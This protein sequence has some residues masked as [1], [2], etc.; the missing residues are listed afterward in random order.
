MFRVVYRPCIIK[1]AQDS[2]RDMAES[3]RGRASGTIAAEMAQVESVRTRSKT[4]RS[5]SQVSGA[6]VYLVTEPYLPMT[7][8]GAAFFVS[9]HE[10]ARRC[11]NSFCSYRADNMMAVCASVQRSVSSSLAVLTGLYACGKSILGVPGT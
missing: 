10:M 8:H 3:A 1:L 4:A 2:A 9:T 7:V 5:C 11:R 6:W